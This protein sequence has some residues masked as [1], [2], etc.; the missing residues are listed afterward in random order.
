MTSGGEGAELEIAVQLN[1]SDTAL[2]H[3][4]MLSHKSALLQQSQGMAFYQ[5]GGDDTAVFYK[6][7]KLVLS[8]GKKDEVVNK[9][10]NQAD[11]APTIVANWL[12]GNLVNRLSHG[13]IT[14]NNCLE[15]YRWVDASADD[16]LGL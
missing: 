4:S 11:M 13:A 16:L 5:K 8:S 1:S 15:T 9:M 14:I 12:S 2:D 7:K 6:A 10:L 3:F